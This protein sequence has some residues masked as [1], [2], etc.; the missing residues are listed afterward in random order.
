MDRL[1][2]GYDAFKESQPK[3]VYASINGVGSVGPTPIGVSMTLLFRRF[4]DLPHY[5]LMAS[6]KWSTA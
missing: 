5:V 4:Q 2:L 1:G 6:L 3:L